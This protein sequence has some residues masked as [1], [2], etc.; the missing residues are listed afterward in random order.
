MVIVLNHRAGVEAGVIIVV[1]VAAPSDGI[2]AGAHVVL[3]SG[4]VGPLVKDEDALAVPA[5]KLLGADACWDIV[6]AP[7][8]LARYPPRGTAGGSSALGGRRWMEIL[9]RAAIRWRIVLLC[10]VSSRCS[11]RLL[12]LIFLRHHLLMELAGKLCIAALLLKFVAS[13]C[14]LHVVCF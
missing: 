12:T 10:G 13:L 8:E 2:A 9:L 4:N 11:C 1:A 7:A 6:L 14:A 3:A 5:E